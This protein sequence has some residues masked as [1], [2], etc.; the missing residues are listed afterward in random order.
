[1]ARFDVHELGDRRTLVLDCQADILRHLNTRLVVPLMRKEDAP[2]PARRLNPILPFQSS[3]Y[4]MVTQFAAAVELREIGLPIGSL[5]SEEVSILN[6]L[7]MLL[8]GI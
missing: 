2:V 3:S 5:A 1:M 7:D 8:T 6:A 4:V